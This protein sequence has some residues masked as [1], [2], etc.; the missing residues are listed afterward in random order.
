M[1]A[2]R[3]RWTTLLIY[4]ICLAASIILLFVKQFNQ[5]DFGLVDSVINVLAL[6]AVP[7][8]IIVTAVSSRRLPESGV[9]GV[10]GTTLILLFGSTLL[11]NALVVGT[12]AYY[13][14]ASI[15]ATRDLMHF[16]NTLAQSFLSS[17]PEKLTFLI[18]GALTYFFVG[19]V[20]K[21]ASTTPATTP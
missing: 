18:S 1:T 21:A 9:T 19:N 20:D 10:T 11:W 2:E 15:N 14:W 3:A 16:P 7:L 13:D 4:L 17:V 6:Y 12:L 5:S 8:S